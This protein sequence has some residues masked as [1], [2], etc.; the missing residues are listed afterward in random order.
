[1][2]TPTAAPPGKTKAP[3]SGS[4][5]SWNEGRSALIQFLEDLKT[6]LGVLVNERLPDETQ[7]LFKVVL[8]AAGTKIDS[9][10][11]VL[12]KIEQGDENHKKL[13]A[14]ELTGDALLLKIA[15]FYDSCNA[16]P[17]VEVL[18]SGDIILGSLISVFPILEPVKE[19]K[20]V[21]EQRLK[22]GG[23]RRVIESLNLTGR[24]QWWHPKK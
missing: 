4:L 5:N 20:E 16:R 14:A 17:P 6:L 2:P 13:E 24:E 19:Y 12:K 15:E 11:E 18:S 9:V 3:G 22:N 23:D 1:M 7:P 10:V 21:V 8:L